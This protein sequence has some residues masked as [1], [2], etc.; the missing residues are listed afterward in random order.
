MICIVPEV[1]LT[2]VW[3]CPTRLQTTELSERTILDGWTYL[4]PEDPPS[5]ATKAS[6]KCEGRNVT[7]KFGYRR[8]S[9]IVLF[10][11]RIQVRVGAERRCKGSDQ[12]CLSSRSLCTIIYT[13][14]LFLN[15]ST[16]IERKGWR[17]NDRTRETRDSD[18]GRRWTQWGK[19]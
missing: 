17:H 6:R 13:N 5:S 9:F 3:L 15:M 18:E 11:I 14:V 19:Y 4:Q 2:G 12:P 8:S 16:V 7:R 1:N 10:E